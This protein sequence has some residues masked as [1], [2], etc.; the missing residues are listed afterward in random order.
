M[1][2]TN[3]FSVAR[4]GDKVWVRL[5][6]KEEYGTVIQVLSGL[7]YAYPLAVVMPESEELLF[8]MQGEYKIS[9]PQCLFWDRPEVIA[10][11]RPRRLVKKVVKVR[12]RIGGGKDIYLN[13][14]TFDGIDWC[15]PEQ[16]IEILVEE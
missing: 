3:D 11:E 12:P 5:A 6:S 9:G 15:G 4:V 16:N 10:P 8:T 13:T 7:E 2:N 1:S 14:V